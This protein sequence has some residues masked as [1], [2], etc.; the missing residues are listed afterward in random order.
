MKKIVRAIFD[1]SSDA[2]VDLKIASAM[3][4]DEMRD[5]EDFDRELFDKAENLVQKEANLLA[6]ARHADNFESCDDDFSN[7]DKLFG[8]ETQE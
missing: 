5:A 6:K 8:D 7:L 4:F 1:K 3:V 2:N